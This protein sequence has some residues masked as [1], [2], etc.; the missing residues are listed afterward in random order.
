VVISGRWQATRC[1]VPVGLSKGGAV[2]SLSAHPPRSADAARRPA[3]G[4]RGEESVDDLWRRYRER[5]TRDARNHLL[6]H[7]APIVKFC[8]GRLRSSVPPEVETADLVSY[9]VFGLANAIE[10]F[11]PAVG[12]KFETYACTRI[13]GAIRDELRSLDWVPRSV[14][15]KA[16]AIE[17]TRTKLQGD[18]RR[19]PVDRE[20]AEALGTS[21]E[22]F[23][24]A[25]SEITRTRLLALDEPAATDDQGR[26]SRLAATIADPGHGPFEEC[27]LRMNRQIVLDALAQ[28]PDRERLVMTRYYFEGCTLARIAASLHVSESRVCQIHARAL[29][30][31][32]ERSRAWGLT[33][34]ED[35]ALSMSA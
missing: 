14:R 7:Y 25:S 5:P 34:H 11:D 24:R 33:D 1:P 35:F 19:T 31:L 20:I 6:L 23:R 22:A 15:T 10:R 17:Q 3:V 9:G 4:R 12:V 18:L 26:S 32:R 30:R 16:S 13:T 28:L 21:E 8:V 29:R 2:T 27:E